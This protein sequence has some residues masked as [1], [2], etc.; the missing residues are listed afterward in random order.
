MRTVKSRYKRP[1]IGV[2]IASEH[3]TGRKDL[4]T[5]LIIQDSAGNTL[6]KRIIRTLDEAWTIPM[7]CA[8]ISGINP[9]W[10]SN[11]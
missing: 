2:V 1:W 3:R 9:D 8:D 7:P 11:L 4:L 5:I 10:F 6:R